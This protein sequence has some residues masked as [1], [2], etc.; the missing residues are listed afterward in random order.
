MVDKRKQIKLPIDGM[1]NF[2]KGFSV[3]MGI[4]LIHKRF[5]MRSNIAVQEEIWI[6][7]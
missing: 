2:I 4:C 6:I 3:T 1:G 5:Q 7:H